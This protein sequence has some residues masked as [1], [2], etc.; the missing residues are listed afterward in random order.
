MRAAS[1]GIAGVAS[2]IG[3]VF[4]FWLARRATDLNQTILLVLMAGIVGAFVY[5][6]G[7]R[8][9]GWA[10]WMIAPAV[11]WPVLGASL[12]ALLAMR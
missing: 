9:A 10:R 12:G 4:P 1:L 7:F 3:L 2:V 8:L 6:A 11:T 5:G